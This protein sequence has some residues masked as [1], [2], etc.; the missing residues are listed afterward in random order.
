VLVVEIQNATCIP[1][2]QSTQYV[3]LHIAGSLASHLRDQMRPRNLLIQRRQHRWTI[4]WTVF[5]LFY[6]GPRIDK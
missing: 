3:I 4:L 6:T 2:G 1:G 5:A